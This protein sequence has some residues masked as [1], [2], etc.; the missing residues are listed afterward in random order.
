MQLQAD[1]TAAIVGGLMRAYRAPRALPGCGCS[2]LELAAHAA[3]IAGLKDA[4]WTRLDEA[5]RRAA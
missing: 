5:A 4:L 2:A 1:G 3:F